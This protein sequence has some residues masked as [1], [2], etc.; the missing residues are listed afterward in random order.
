MKNIFVGNLSFNTAED[1]LRQAFEAYGQVDRVSIMTDR[2]TGRSRGFGFVE[3]ASNEDGEK[4][5]AALNGSQLGGRTVNVNEARPKTE[6]SS[7]SGGGGG[8]GRDRGER[9]GRGGGG[10]HRDRW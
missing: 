8:G 9:G 1:E 2:D 7:G 5:I 6:R 4:A 10:G 3:M